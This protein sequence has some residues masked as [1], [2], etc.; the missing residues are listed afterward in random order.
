VIALLLLL[1]AAHAAAAEITATDL[2]L[3]RQGTLPIIV[4]APHG[5]RDAVPGIEP[6][7]DRSS[8]GDYRTWGGFQKGTDLNTDV[9]AQGIAA[10]IATLTG[11]EPYLVVAK[12]QRKYIDA[13]RPPQ[14]ALDDRK[15]R[16]YYE[17]YHATIRRFVHEVRRGHGGGLLI[18]VH[19][20]GKD[21]DVIMRG[22]L[23]GHAVERL[24]W[25]S[26][27]AAV[28]GPRGLFGQLEAYGFKIFP[29]NDVPPR[30]G[31]EDAGFIGGWTL[32]LYGSHNRHGIDAVQ[33]EFGTRYRDTSTVDVTA[34][35]AAKAI[36]AFWEAYLKT[37][38]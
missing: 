23:N 12:F 35:D 5:G 17:H 37:P 15:A 27:A 19:G 25:R 28:T 21:R 20:Q 3:V 6:R 9:L 4:T 32:D 1:I 14:L 2:V 36:A 26:G 22:T 18:D 33:L 10:G 8:A 13:N 16:P 29:A 31:S 38:R 11:A 7:K 24:L 34:R 30:E